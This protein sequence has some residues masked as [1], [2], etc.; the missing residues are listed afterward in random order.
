MGAPKS[1]TQPID[2]L[3]DSQEA[4][5]ENIYAQVLPCLAGLAEKMPLDIFQSH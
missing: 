5:E 4:Q 3:S 1:A 2:E